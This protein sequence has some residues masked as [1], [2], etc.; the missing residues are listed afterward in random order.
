VKNG[1]DPKIY[2]NRLEVAKLSH[3]HNDRTPESRKEKTNFTALSKMLAEAIKEVPQN[4]EAGLKAAQLSTQFIMETFPDRKLDSGRAASLG[5][6][7]MMEQQLKEVRKPEEFLKHFKEAFGSKLDFRD[8]AAKDG[9]STLVR[10]RRQVIHNDSLGFGASEQKMFCQRRSELMTAVDKQYG[11]M[12][13]AALGL[14]K[15]SKKGTKR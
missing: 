11:V 15:N 7:R 10:S 3:L 6:F 13:D 8:Y 1:F 2:A 4:P 9:F 5:Q 12:R 14:D